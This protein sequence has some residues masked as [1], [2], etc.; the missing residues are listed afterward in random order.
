MILTNKPIVRRDQPDLVYKNEAGKFT[1]GDRPTSSTATGAGSR[2]WSASRVGREERGRRQLPARA[3]TSRSTS[4][5][6]S[7]TS[8]RPTSSRRRGARA[9]SRSRRTWPAAAPT[10]SLGGNP[11]AMAKEALAEE[12]AKLAATADA[13]KPAAGEE[14]GDGEPY[15]GSVEPAFDEDKAAEELPRSSR[16][17]AR[18]SARRCSK[19]AASRSSAPSATSRGASTT[20]CAVAPV[21]RATPARR[22]STCRCRTTCCASSALEQDDRPLMERLGLEEDVPIES[23]DG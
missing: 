3:R 11:E 9:P 22:G 15:R 8:A 7:S 21:A 1:R 12:K 4:S 13:A 14:A 20:S 17:S 23:P 6:P 2:C 19:R 5:T 10:S 18:P 16:R